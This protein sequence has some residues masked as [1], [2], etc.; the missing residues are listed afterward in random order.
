MPGPIATVGSNQLCP[1]CTG[2][3][4]H[5]GGPVAQ[6]SANVFVG[7][8]PVATVG[9]LCTCVGPPSTIIQGDGRVFVNGMPV[10]TMNSM[11]SHGGAVVNGD[12]TVIVGTKMP[13]PSVCTPADRIGNTQQQPSG[14]EREDEAQELRQRVVEKESLKNGYLGSF[15][16]SV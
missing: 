3:T 15:D 8:L 2:P 1:M 6:G 9:S 13:S 14:D 11:T 12:P 10:A 5:V 16:F 7:G 4:P